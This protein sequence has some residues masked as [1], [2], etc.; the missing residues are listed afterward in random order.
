MNK[1][2]V[3]NPIRKIIF[4]K[5]S[6]FLNLIGVSRAIFLKLNNFQFFNLEIKKGARPHLRTKRYRGVAEMLIFSKNIYN[7]LSDL[8]P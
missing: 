5:N 7:Y 2:L 8:I 3:F 6:Q 1:K 4:N